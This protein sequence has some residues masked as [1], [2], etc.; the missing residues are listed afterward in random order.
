M[1]NQWK[2]RKTYFLDIGNELSLDVEPEKERM[3]LW[4]EIFDYSPVTKVGNGHLK[5]C[6]RKNLDGD[7]FLAFLGIPYA[8]PPVGKLRFKAP[9]PA[10]PWDDIR[11]ATTDGNSCYFRNFFT[12]EY[13]GSEDCLFLNV[14]T[15]ELPHKNTKLKPVMVYIHG[16]G[17]I[18]ESSNSQVFGFE[19]LIVEDI[20]FVSM[21][22]R[23]GVLGFLSS[24]DESLGVPGNMGLKD[25][26]LALQWV[27]KNIQNFNG[28]PNNVTIFGN[29]AG[30]TSVHFHILSKRS[31]GLFHKAILQSGTVFNPWSWGCK[32]IME[33]VKHL[34]K[35]VKSEKE[36]LEILKNTPVDELYKAETKILDNISARTHRPLGPVIEVPNETAFITKHPIEI[37]LS[38]EYNKVPMIFGYNLTEGMF[39]EYNPKIFSQH[40]EVPLSAENV[41]DWQLGIE[42][43]SEKYEMVKRK[44]ED[45]YWKSIRR[46]DK[47]LS[48]TDSLYMVGI[49][50]AVLNHVKTM[51]QPVYLYRMTLEGGRNLLKIFGDLSH[52][53]GVSHADELGYL[54]RNFALPKIEPGSADDTYVRRFV[55]LWTNFAK[56]SNP[57]PDQ[58]E[59]NVTWK[60]V[61]EKNVHFLD[62]GKTLVPDSDAESETERINLWRELYK[63]NPK[64][65]NFL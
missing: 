17:F 15:K 61:D 37:I 10:E 64:T 65:A 34:G 46:D 27:Q 25:Q 49:F 22:Y 18:A 20:V 50:A 24:D 55:K 48:F 2:K 9:E 1:G 47:Y 54:F 4:K 62:I 58:R 12:G 23:L 11:D 19:N 36:A 56:T 41:I 13:A 29:S 42:E 3:E 28:D 6:Y 21:N 38:G 60:P 63:L 33:F 16:G 51:E 5:G 32:M 31:K 39:M 53:P 35:V 43:D 40:P 57:T 14:F 59:L 30:S 26:T 45:F 7:E 52:L 8:K 44:I